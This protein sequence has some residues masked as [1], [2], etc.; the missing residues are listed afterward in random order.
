M[1][2]ILKLTYLDLY[3][4]NQIQSEMAQVH[5]FENEKV[6]VYGARISNLLNR[7]IDA[8]K[9]QSRSNDSIEIFKNTA[10]HR[11][12]EGLR[13]TNLRKSMRSQQLSNLGAA[14]EIAQKDES[15]EAIIQN[16]S[17]SPKSNSL[18][19]KIVFQMNDHKLKSVI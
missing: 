15:L 7:A 9:I 4:I 11:F 8:I 17:Q 1:I 19:E 13:D 14:I 18:K 12:I 5:Q 6:R 10:L 16:N 2:K 3:D